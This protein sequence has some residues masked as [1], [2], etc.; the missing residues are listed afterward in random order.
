LLDDRFTSTSTNKNVGGTGVGIKQ[1]SEESTTVINLT[2]ELVSELF[3]EF[4][5]LQ[6]AY[7]RHVPAVSH[8]AGA[9][10]EDAN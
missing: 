3:E 1:K 10:T 4:P 2:K 6:D 9:V 5:V 7:A 8:C